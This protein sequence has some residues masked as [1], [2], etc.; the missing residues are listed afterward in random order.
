MDCNYIR[1]NDIDE[2]YLLNQLPEAERKEYEKHIEDCTSCEDEFQRQTEIIKGI[3]RVGLQ[4]MK[5][6]IQRQVEKVKAQKKIPDWQIILKVAAVIVII[7]IIPGAIYYFQTEQGKPV[8]QLVKPKD[9]KIENESLAFDDARVEDKSESREESVEP[10]LKST[11]SL[12]EPV[13]K[14][15]Q[16]A[17]KTPQEDQ[18]TI[19]SGTASGGAGRGYGYAAADTK[20]IKAIIDSDLIIDDE[21]SDVEQPQIQVATNQEKDSLSQILSTGI[22]YQYVGAESEEEDVSRFKSQEMT[23]AQQYDA[24]T[25]KKLAPETNLMKKGIGSLDSKPPTISN[26]VYKSGEKMISINFLLTEREL[27]INEESKLPQ[28]FEV[29][30]FK[31]DSLNWTMNWHVN[32]GFL[33]YDPYQ[34]KIVVNK[35][36]LYTIILDAYIYE[37]DTSVDTTTAILSR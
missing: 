12:E 28:S 15:K 26:A 14:E 3:Q 10:S 18:L 2:K 35:S 17:G 4:E 36:K 31:R 32:K 25:S 11:T 30:I 34:M 37:I 9:S 23:T 7:A 27:I 6:E 1:Q 29:Q 24:I 5:N 13:K 22:A 8:S 33:E 21:E 16:E 19:S 20:S